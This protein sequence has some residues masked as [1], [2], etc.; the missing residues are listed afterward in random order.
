M[1]AAPYEEKTSDRRTSI[2]NALAWLALC[3]VFSFS[4]LSEEKV[5]AQVN[6]PV[7]E[8]EFNAGTGTIAADSSAG[9]NDG[10]LRGDA[11][12]ASGMG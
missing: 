9:K 8:W 3:L 4:T 5:Q 11:A 2:N 1:S 6:Q 12:R 10:M 7:A